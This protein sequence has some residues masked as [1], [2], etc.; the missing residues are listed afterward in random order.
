M[1][2]VVLLTD[3][4]YLLPK[5]DTYTQNVVL[6][7][8]L[9]IKAL[10]QKGLRVSRTHWDDPNFDW[11][12]TKFVIFRAVWDYFHRIDEF[13]KWFAATSKKTRF[14]NSSAL[15][16]WNLDKHYL[17]DLANTGVHIPKTY[18]I[19]KNAVNSLAEAIEFAKNKAGI[20]TDV[21]ILKPCIAGGA[22]H[23]YKFKQSEQY[24]L[25]EVFLQL[26]SSE[27]MMIQE[28]QEHIVSEGEISLVFFGQTYSH[29][30]LKKAKPGDFRVQDD[31]GGS[32]QDYQP[33]DEEINFALHAVKAAPELPVYSRIDMFK[34]NEGKVALAELELF[35][36]ELW[37]RKAKEAPTIFANYFVEQYFNSI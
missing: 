9:V 13:K 5:E 21:L 3:R 4:R 25:N 37:F 12:T 18:F 23:T 35:E 16:S 19:E 7:D 8:Q 10:K 15:V 29:A 30:I 24:S 2:D 20:K 11:S 28:F 27:A 26:I 22:R 6:E 36:P 33:T 14:I 17:I 32:I 1:F 34:D 31:F